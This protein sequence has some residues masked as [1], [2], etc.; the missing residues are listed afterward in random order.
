MHKGESLE[1]TIRIA[2]GEKEVGLKILERCKHKTSSKVS[3]P[4]DNLRRT[5]AKQHAKELYSDV[6]L[7]KSTFF[8]NKEFRTDHSERITHIQVNKNGKYFITS[9]PD[10]VQ[11]W[12]L[13]DL[14][15]ILT[16]PL[17]IDDG[18]D[19]EQQNVVACMDA[20]GR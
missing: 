13:K 12:Q 11:I 14:K 2:L 16:I 3:D 18:V 10:K 5:R 9:S 19:P 4:S 15:S 7:N 1:G 20:K 8:Q 6:N 17:E